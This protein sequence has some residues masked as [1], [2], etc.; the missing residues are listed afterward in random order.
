MTTYDLTKLSDDE[1]VVHFGGRPSEVDVYTFTNAMLGIADALR[2]INAIINPGQS[3]EV[4]IDALGA[5][6]FRTRIKTIKRFLPALLHGTAVNV[7]LP[8]FLM[9]LYDRY[10]ADTSFSV[11]VNDDVVVIH[12]GHDRI[13]I[14]K[15]AHEKKSMVSDN[16]KVADGVR[17]AIEA[18]REDSSVESIAFV[19]NMH[20]REPSLIIP[21]E[22]F[23]QVLDK[24]ELL[25]TV[26]EGRTRTISERTHLGVIKAVFER[27][28]R[29]WQF[30]WR[31]IRISAS[32]V[33]ASF[34]DRLERREI[35]IAQGDSLDVELAI[36]QEF[37]P[38]ARVWINEGY[39]VVRVFDIVRGPRQDAFNA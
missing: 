9:F 29:K 24:V 37:D 7:V 23:D 33:D 1:F 31:G 21:R 28:R 6:S 8:L 3:L 5:G 18:V 35:A 38:A 32:I 36:F 15:Q 30:I 39:E 14:S 19:E 27:S 13:I 20:V 25:A 2:E 17:R 12:R 16:P 11:E 22:G 26:P 34:F 10:L 4:K